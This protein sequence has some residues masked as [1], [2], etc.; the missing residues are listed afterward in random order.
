VRSSGA[1]QIA[2]RMS[3]KLVLPAAL[4]YDYH[5]DTNAFPI[6]SANYELCTEFREALVGDAPLEDCRCFAGECP[7][8]IA[9]DAIR[10]DRRRVPKDLGPRICPSGFWGYRHALGLPVT[11]HDRGADANDTTRDAPSYIVF[12][13]K[14]RVALGIS[15]DPKFKRFPDHKLALKKLAILLGE[16]STTRDDVL[17]MLKTPAAEVI[18]L[19]CHGGVDGK[20]PFLSVGPTHSDPITPD[21][22]DLLWDDEETPLVFINGCHTTALHPEAALDFVSTFVDARASGVIGTEITISESLAC[23]FAEQCLGRFLGTAK[24]ADPEMTIAESVRGARL[25]LLQM[26]NPLGLVYIPF[27]VSSLRLKAA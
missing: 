5:F 3:E 16:A 10:R 9:S 18:Y 2:L 17:R 4:I 24:A 21:N 8:R 15:T 19:Y 13:D 22:I 20:T 1:V 26:G 23:A 6:A 12:R 14:A 11:I 25:A 7:V 27:S